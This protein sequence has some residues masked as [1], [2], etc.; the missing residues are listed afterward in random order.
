ML[1]RARSNIAIGLAA[2]AAPLLWAG[3]AGAQTVQDQKLQ[4]RATIGDVCRV[5]SASLDFG[6]GVIVG[7]QSNTDASG[8][9]DINCSAETSVAVKLDGGLQ[10]GSGASRAMQGAG[11]NLLYSLYT[12]TPGGTPWAPADTVTA[13][14]N[15]DG[16]VPVHGRIP[17]QP[18]GHSDGLYTDEVTITL[19]F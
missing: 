16:S 14:I 9:I 15:G 8:E 11:G 18:N 4:V 7:P 10:P 12:D 5:T 17:G 2:V 19:V 1:S 6:S 13:T 3:D